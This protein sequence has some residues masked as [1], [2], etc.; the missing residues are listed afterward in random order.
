M[1]ATL[2][3]ADVNGDTFGNEENT[4]LACSVPEGYVTNTEDCNDTND[5]VSPNAT[6]FCNGVNDSVMEKSMR[7]ESRLTTFTIWMMTMMDMVKQIIQ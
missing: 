5:L 6:E 7:L 2:F 4:I 3:Y 1:N